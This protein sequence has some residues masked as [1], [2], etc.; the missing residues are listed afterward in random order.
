MTVPLISWHMLTPYYDKEV[1]IYTKLSNTLLVYFWLHNAF[2]KNRR[3]HYIF[4]DYT[5]QKLLSPLPG[6]GC[7]TSTVC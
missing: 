4:H 2:T 5:I 1:G 6:G 3:T 7:I